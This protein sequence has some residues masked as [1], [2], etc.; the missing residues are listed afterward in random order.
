MKRLYA[1]YNYLTDAACRIRLEWLLVAGVLTG[2]ACVSMAYTVIAAVPSLMIFLPGWRRWMFAAAVAAGVASTL[3]HEDWHRGEYGYLLD[4]KNRGGEAVLRFNDS[5]LSSLEVL[6]APWLTEAEVLAVRL[7]GEKH[8]T[9]VSGNIFVRLPYGF[10][11]RIQYGDIWRMSGIFEARQ[12]SRI[13]YLAPDGRTLDRPIKLRRDFG[14]YLRARRVAAVF[15]ADSAEYLDRRPGL[16]G[17]LLPVRDFIAGAI[18]RNMKELRW[19]KASAALFCGCRNGLDTGSKLDYIRSGTI[20][21]FVVSGFHVGL[22]A[23]FLLQIFRPL[24]FRLRYTLLPAA[25]LLFV[26]TTGCNVPAVRAWWMIA[27]WSFLRAMLYRVPPASVLGLVACGMILINPAVIFDAGFLYSFIITG[28]LLVSAGHMDG[29]RKTGDI[30]EL[31]PPDTALFRRRRRF[32]KFRGKILAVFTGCLI[33]FLAGS[34]ITLYSRGMWLPGSIPAN[35]FLLPI[36]GVMFQVAGLKLLLGWIWSGI[37]RFFAVMLELLFELVDGITN[38]VA[39]TFDS[40]SMRMPQIWEFGCFYAGLFLLLYRGRG[41]AFR[42]TAG[43]LLVLGTVLWWH[44]AGNMAVN[45]ALMIIRNGG[46]ETPAIAIA[47]PVAGTGTAVNVPDR[48]SAAV[49]A[50]FFRRHGIQRVDRILFSSYRSGAAGGLGALMQEMPVNVLQLP[51]LKT[52]GEHFF[53]RRIARS[54]GRYPGTALTDSPG[55]LCRFTAKNSEN[56]V[57]YFNPASDFK[58]NAVWNDGDDRYFRIHTPYNKIT[59]PW[60]NSNVTEVSE[61]GF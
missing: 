51:A 3:W 7:A 54:I 17:R 32:L 21:I 43:G 25:A 49:M 56:C 19:Q 33:A 10:D 60:E 2:I 61:Y 53:R 41:G 9:A 15:S 6:P 22:I 24:P 59:V 40:S 36:A 11:K 20:H 58:V 30:S 46:M 35:I 1:F 37:D 48:D 38:F 27:A 57:E 26:L 55:T 44:W 16:T 52:S 47:D 42:R 8:D 14:D 23:F 34:A 18:M 12:D 29:G 45:P 31:M 5:A 4:G 13:F 50:D 28:A 39:V